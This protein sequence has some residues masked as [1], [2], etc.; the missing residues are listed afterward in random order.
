MSKYNKY[1]GIVVQRV[2]TRKSVEIWLPANSTK[3]KI[4]RALVKESQ[5]ESYTRKW[6]PKT[7]TNLSKAKVKTWKIVGTKV[8]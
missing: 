6:I 3:A 2:E 7:N 1:H 5:N 8:G 4:K